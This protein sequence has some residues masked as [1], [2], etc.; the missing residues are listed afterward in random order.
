MG[1][2]ILACKNKECPVTN[3]SDSVWTGVS[4][5]SFQADQINTILAWVGGGLFA[6]IIASIIAI[7]ILKR[8]KNGGCCGTQQE[9]HEECVHIEP[10][11]DEFVPTYENL[12]NEGYPGINERYTKDPTN[13]NQTSINDNTLYENVNEHGHQKTDDLKAY[14]NNDHICKGIYIE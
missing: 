11:Y 12:G 13:T 5:T 10:D 7:W 2:H 3:V 9:R 1:D 8:H 14:A 6:L 4:R